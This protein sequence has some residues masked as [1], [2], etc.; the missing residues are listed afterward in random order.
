M[1]GC[2]YTNNN[3]SISLETHYEQALAFH[4]NAVYIFYEKQI[5]SIN[6]LLLNG[7]DKSMEEQEEEVKLTLM[8]H[9]CD[10][11]EL[12]LFVKRQKS[13][14]TNLS[15]SN[16]ENSSPN[17]VN[18][19]LIETKV[20]LFETNATT[21]NDDLLRVYNGNK[22]LY[23]ENC[24]LKQCEHDLEIVCLDLH[25]LLSQ[26]Q[27]SMLKLEE[28][29]AQLDKT[30]RNGV[31]VWRINDYSQRS[32]DPIYSPAFYTS[33]INGYR[34]CAKLY[35]N[36]DGKGL[37]THLS[38]YLIVLKGDFDALATWP[39]QLKFSFTLMDQSEQ[40]CHITETIMPDVASNSA[41]FRRP[42]FEMNVPNGLPQFVPIE[43]L[44]NKKLNYLKMNT[45]FIKI[46]VGV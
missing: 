8:T 17:G 34:V 13:D 36:G 23:E 42:Q 10:K 26:S 30:V 45:L 31:I 39:F 33:E 46:C 19:N 28:R 29:L 41:S 24:Q 14:E 20:K 35:L 27:L 11:S 32:V 37:N 16:N 22:K 25:K 4:L 43:V 38:I 7:V 6:S 15:N 12:N 1:Y 40:R 3:N 9:H 21:L 5:N 18:L 2:T 44:T